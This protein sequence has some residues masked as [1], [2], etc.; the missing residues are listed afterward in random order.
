MNSMVRSQISRS[1]KWFAKV[2]RRP[3]LMVFLPAITLFAFWF[4]GEQALILTAL[5]APLIFTVS[6]AFRFKGSAPMPSPD[7][8]SGLALR[9]QVV[10]MLDTALQDSASGSRMKI[11]RAHV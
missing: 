8:L 7:G 11:G 10:A 6:G 5:A 9:P 1:L 2:L 3:E 4:G